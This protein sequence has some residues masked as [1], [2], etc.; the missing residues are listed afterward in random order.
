[1]NRGGRIQRFQG[2]VEKV[3]PAVGVE[4][5]F[6]AWE[7]REYHLRR[8]SSEVQ[9]ERQNRTDKR[10]VKV[11]SAGRTPRQ[12]KEEMRKGAKYKEEKTSREQG[13]KLKDR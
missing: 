13:K 10:T 4:G 8:I 12:E 1:M 6:L 3:L 2:A 9:I 5:E 11:W 7:I